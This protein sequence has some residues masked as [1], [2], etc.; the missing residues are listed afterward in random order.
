MW[1]ITFEVIGWVECTLSITATRRACLLGPGITH[2]PYDNWVMPKMWLNGIFSRVEV[3]LLKPSGRPMYVRTGQ[4]LSYHERASNVTWAPVYDLRMRAPESRSSKGWAP[5]NFGLQ[6]GEVGSQGSGHAV[7][8][9]MYQWLSQMYRRVNE[10]PTFVPPSPCAV[11]HL[12]WLCI[13]LHTRGMRNKL[14][15]IPG[16]DERKRSTRDMPSRDGWDARP[17]AVHWGNS[18]LRSLSTGSLVGH[19]RWLYVCNLVA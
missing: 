15:F 5:E 16:Q 18:L 14:L 7:N 13:V 19:L 9:W 12:S 4:K 17:S 2:E 3:R 8:W 6:E 1:L 11:A 10:H